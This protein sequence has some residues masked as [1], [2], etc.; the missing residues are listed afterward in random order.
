M[1]NNNYKQEKFDS[2]LNKTIILSSRTY[3]K[4]QM[5]T[6]K[7]ENTI[8]DNE[9]Y[10]AFLQGFIDVNCPS[11]SIDDVDSA[12]ELNAA[13]N[14]LSDIEQA[15]I[16]LLFNQGQTQEFTAEKLNLYST[17]VSRIRNRALKKLRK[18][19]EKGDL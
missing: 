5:N 4:K 17:S 18:M 10:S 1:E 16:F 6:V 9:D 8:L 19:I 12:L 7:K 3:F 13:L 14:C 15:V 11:S 2:F